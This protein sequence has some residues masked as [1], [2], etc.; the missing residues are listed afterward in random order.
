MKKVSEEEW[1][2]AVE[3]ISQQLDIAMREL[4]SPNS[5]EYFQYCED[6]RTDEA[7]ALA[8]EHFDEIYGAGNWEY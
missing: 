8:E 3:D 2:D 5:V 7:C 4:I 1:V 6:A